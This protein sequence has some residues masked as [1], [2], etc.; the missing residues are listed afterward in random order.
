MRNPLRNPREISGFSHVWYQFVACKVEEFTFCR[1][2]IF[3][4]GWM[5]DYIVVFTDMQKLLALF[6]TK[7][8]VELIKKNKQRYNFW[9]QTCNLIEAPMLVHSG[10]SKV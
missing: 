10:K 2:G 5:T 6:G 7:T 4:L 3:T 8:F 1:Y 9:P